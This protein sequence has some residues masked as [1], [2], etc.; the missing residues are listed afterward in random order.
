MAYSFKTAWNDAIAEVSTREE[1]QTARI[2]IEDPSRLTR[3]YNVATG[4]WTITGD[5]RI[6]PLGD[7]S[8]QARIIGV[9]W[10]VQSGGESQANATTI[11]AIRI[12]VP[13]HVVGR[14]KRGLK[15]HVTSSPQNPTLTNFVFTVN[16]DMQGSAAAARTFEC[17]LDLDY[18]VPNG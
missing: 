4:K 11:S 9:R 5:S 7:E 15:V 12:Q 13:Q 18:Q 1:F 14:V 3:E 8:G 6:Y 17:A 2:R 10:G 16:S